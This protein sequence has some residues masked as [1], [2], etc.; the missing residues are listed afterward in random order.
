[1]DTRPLNPVEIGRALHFLSRTNKWF[2]GVSTVLRP[3]EVWSHR[4][5][6]GEPVHMLD[7]G[8]GGADIPIALVQ[9]ARKKGYSLRVTALELV[10]EIAAI[11]KE[12]VRSYPEITVLCRNLWDLPKELT[13]DYVTASLFLHHRP[14]PFRAEALSALDRRA[15]RGV[16][17]SDLQR[18]L[19]SYW[20][21]G[22]SSGIWGDGVV[23]HDG[24][25]SVRR[26][27]RVAELEA[28]ANQAGLPYLK[29][30]RESWFRISLTGEKY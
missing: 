28:L 1:M 14:I 17:V 21:V 18:T 16:I 27:F 8:T 9:W 30:R 13:F 25:L 11:A 29:A 4:W 19:G 12:A 3:L 24:P 15:R 26:S 2:G 10:P 7:V 20:G 5:I 22:F 6:P 23:R